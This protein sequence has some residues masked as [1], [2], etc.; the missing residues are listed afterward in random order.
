MLTGR[1][2]VQ[3]MIEIRVIEA[4]R[5]QDI[6]IPND[7]FPLYGRMIPSYVDEQ[8]RY[9]VVNFEEDAVSEMCF[10]D[11]HY[12][13]DAMRGDHTFI[14]AY[15]GEKCVGLAILRDAWLRYLY[16]YDL[17]VS[18]A[19]RRQGVARALI[20]KAKEISVARGYRGLYTQGQDNNL[21][22]CLF[23]IQ[24]GFVIGGFDSNVYKGSNQEGKSDII[25]YLDC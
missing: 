16:L 17:K 1:E 4:D 9:D 13:Y 8:W 21:S 12:D 6:N 7:P 22:A 18:R 3:P 15:D 19:Y 10:P 24:S 11:E 5:R 2:C 20:E 14:G 23:Y 25:F